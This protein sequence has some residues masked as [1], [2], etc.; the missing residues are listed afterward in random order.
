[1]SKLSDRI[2]RLED[3]NNIRRRVGDFGEAC[4]RG[5]YDADELS[6]YWLSDASFHSDPFHYDGLSEIRQFFQGLAAD[7]TKHY[8]LNPII[9]VDESG[10]TATAQWYGW[11]SPAIAGKSLVGAFDH[12]LRCEK[13]QGDWLWGKWIQTIQFLSPACAGW[14]GENRLIEQHKPSA[15]TE[16]GPQDD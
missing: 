14:S 6:E 16:E 12:T 10:S 5:P 4:D 2:T 13:R 7:F 9:H 8:F 3:I 11:E 1:M 15:C